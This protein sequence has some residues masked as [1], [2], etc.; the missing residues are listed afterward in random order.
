[1]EELCTMKYTIIVINKL[2][3]LSDN[4][5]KPSIKKI[6]FE[7]ISVAV[8]AILEI[9]EILAIPVLVVSKFAENPQ[10]WLP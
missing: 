1:M 6:K 4:D 10:A 8:V 2:N 5:R 3:F 7:A 9:L